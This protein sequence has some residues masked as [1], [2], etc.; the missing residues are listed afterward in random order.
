MPVLFPIYTKNKCKT[1]FLCVLK[2]ATTTI[3]CVKKC[4]SQ[5][6]FDRGVNPYEQGARPQQGDGPPIVCVEGDIGYIVTECIW[7]CHQVVNIIIVV[8]LRIFKRINHF[9]T[10]VQAKSIKQTLQDFLSKDTGHVGHVPLF[11]TFDLLFGLN[12][13][14]FNT[15]IASRQAVLGLYVK[16]LKPD[17]FF[18]GKPSQ[19]SLYC[20]CISIH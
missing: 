8:F 19:Y 5:S 11:S 12:L 1:S 18:T 6:L 10:K 9:L 13:Q 14:R 7:R 17:K 20:H 2:T 16:K 15:R 4:I 3:G